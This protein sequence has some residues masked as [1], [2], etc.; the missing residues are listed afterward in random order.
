ML[1]IYKHASPLGRTRLEKIPVYLIL[2]RFHDLTRDALQANCGL[3]KEAR[4]CAV[5]KAVMA[6]LCEG[7][8]IAGG[9]M[10]GSVI[11]CP[12]VA[13]TKLNPGGLKV[14]PLDRFDEALQGAIRQAFIPT[15]HTYRE[16]PECGPGRPLVIVFATLEALGAKISEGHLRRI[17]RRPAHVRTVRPAVGA[18]LV[19]QV[20]RDTPAR[21]VPFGSLNPEVMAISRVAHG[22]AE[23]RRKPEVFVDFYLRD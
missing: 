5:S 14:D 11:W 8:R 1:A 13:I 15:P 4:V 16:R 18:G 10:H 6:S 22:P 3:G 7:M 21:L 17:V 23:S 20:Y 9:L 12:I 2:R 19:L